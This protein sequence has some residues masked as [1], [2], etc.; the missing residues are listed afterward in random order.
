[1]I[2]GFN[3][4]GFVVQDLDRMVSFYRDVLGLKVLREHPSI[5]EIL[6]R[7]VGIPGAQRMLVFVGADADHH[8]L[9]LVHYLQ[10]PSP[11][12]HVPHNALGAAHICFNV[13]GLQEYYERMVAQGLEFVT[14]PVVRE[15]PAGT[16]IICYARD[17][18]GNWLE[19]L[20]RIP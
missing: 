18:E 19:F 12:G 9:E 20:E 13:T 16:T 8:A 6:N 2:T 3:H 7:H 4:S 11:E 10:P 17:P 15:S 1:M 5:E 14:P